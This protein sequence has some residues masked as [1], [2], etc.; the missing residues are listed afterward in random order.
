M[1]D[2]NPK[3]TASA[4]A[5]QESRSC[6]VRTKFAKMKHKENDDKEK[7]AKEDVNKYVFIAFILFIILCACI[8]GLFYYATYKT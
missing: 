1:K 3:P 4:Q 5:A 8:V 2:P 7:W 6:A